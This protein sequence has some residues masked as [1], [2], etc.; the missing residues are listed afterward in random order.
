M[1]GIFGFMGSNINNVDT[2]KIIN[3]LKHRGPDD[4]GVFN[5]GKLLLVH[6]R[7][8]ILDLSSNGHQ[9]MQ[10]ED[11]DT[12]ICFNGEIY[13]H[14]E[15]RKELSEQHSVKF[16]SDSDTETLL[17][18]YKFW[19]KHLLNKLNGIFAF[20]IYEKK[21]GKILVVRDNFGIKPLYIYQKNGNT[22]FSSE[23]KAFID[24]PEFDNTLNPEVFVNYVNY[25]WSPGTET[26]FKYV[27]KLSA[28][29]YVEYDLKSGTSAF[30]KYYE[31][32]FTGTYLEMSEQEIIDE[33]DKKLQLAVKRQLL[34]DVPVAFF[35]SG[36]LDSSLLVAMATNFMNIP[37]TA[38]TIDT[39]QLS[40]TEG[41]SDDLHYA[42]LVAKHLNVNLQVVKADISITEDFD[43]MIYH[44]DEPQADAAPLN[45]LN[46]CRAAKADGF[47]VMIGGTAGDDVFSGYRRHQAIGFEKY[48]KMTPL[49]LRRIL[50]TLSRNMPVSSTLTRRLKKLF[51]EIDI[52]VADRLANYFNWLPYETLRNLFRSEVFKGYVPNK[53]LHDLLAN[54]PGEKS[55]LNKMLY[56]EMKTFLV[57][58]NLNYTDKMS[59]AEGVEVRVPFLD[60][61]LVDFACRINPNLKLRGNETKYILK[62]VAERYLPHEVIYRSKAGF[63][64][65]VRSWIVSDLSDKVNFELSEKNIQATKVFNFV[66]VANLI[67]DN[68]T[69]K[70]DASYSIWSMLAIQSWIRTFTKH[71]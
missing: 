52:P 38:Y 43:K 66:H 14:Q 23:I 9:P 64:A 67:D 70:V 13:N 59:M 16:K 21:E 34:S 5:D 12:V 26:P 35:L 61:D 11:E 65:P 40:K 4:H 60:V 1:C 48:F 55:W 33:L 69:G 32:P 30:S 29:F 27:T 56:W 3:T 46:I 71:R 50:K 49:P 8:S 15:L 20:I 28:G 41:F 53:F 58:H 57:D 19:G 47:K 17:Y 54:I 39:S 44:L 22:A 62:K 68:K 45:V 18:G 63:G 31:I 42:R 24:L 2:D 51:N 6:L 25:L 10:S 36:G 7:L 37:A